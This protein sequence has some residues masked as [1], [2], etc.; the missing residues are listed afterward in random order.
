MATV[1]HL[2]LF[3]WCLYPD[4]EA[5]KNNVLNVPINES[6]YQYNINIFEG[7]LVP[8]ATAMK[9]YW[10]VKTWKATGSFQ[11]RSR[12]ETEYPSGVSIT[13]DYSYTYRRPNCQT[14][15]DLVCLSALTEGLQ[16]QEPLL[17]YSHPRS[18]VT[19]TMSNAEFD[20]V[21]TF[22]SA[23][24][25]MFENEEKKNV[26]VWQNVAFNGDSE[27]DMIFSSRIESQNTQPVLPPVPIK[28]P[29]SAFSQSH[30]ISAWINP[31]PSPTLPL[32]G[33]LSI[34]AIEYWP[35]DPGDGG[36]PIYDSATGRQLRPFPS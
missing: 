35:Y 5:V 2:G 14:E 28:V 11:A 36:G 3:P 9:F 32:S 8:L 6:L 22:G 23:R 1:R 33:S 26:H 25:G 19:L 31:F 21:S 7:L 12:P 13:V 4:K 34:E 29:L 27:T 30:E 18:P 16:R 20:I 10:V 15:K 17:E 24:T